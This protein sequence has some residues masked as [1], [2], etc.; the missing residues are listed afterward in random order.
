MNNN[1]NFA[2]PQELIKKICPSCNKFF[3]VSKH[4]KEKYHKK[5]CSR[6]CSATF[7]NKNRFV[8]EEQRINLSIKCKK[9]LAEKGPWG[10]IRI[11]KP[12]IPRICLECKK[13]FVPEPKRRRRKTCSQVCL[14][15][16]RTNNMPKPKVVGGYRPGSG[17]SKHGYYKGIYCGSTYELC[18]V[19]YNLDHNIKF[20]RFSSCLEKDGLKYYPDFILEDNKTIIEI[21]GY[22]SPELVE[23]KN[24]L[25]E[26]F[27]YKVIVLRKNDLKDI[28][29][30]VKQKYN[31]TEFQKLYDDFKPTYTYKCM[32]CNK[33]VF[34]EIKARPNKGIFCSLKC[35]GCYSAIRRQKARPTG[36]EP[37][38]LTGHSLKGW[39]D[40]P[41]S[42]R[43]L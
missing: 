37:A 1:I 21:K 30:Y 8:S 5:F 17:R 40:S 10:A 3:N 11:I 36:L 23:R 9:R 29:D 18:W 22:E 6:S 32:N 2:R 38:S 14:E 16:Y 25:A 26:S 19:I 7:N 24:K 34:R 28:F 41:A 15:K 4:L 13:E 42:A 33:D 39:P 27:G 12:V 35:S 31:T 20:T 43:P